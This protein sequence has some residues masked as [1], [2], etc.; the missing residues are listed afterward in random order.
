MKRLRSVLLIL[1]ILAPAFST[2]DDEISVADLLGN[3]NRQDD[4]IV[5][6]SHHTLWNYDWALSVLLR[7]MSDFQVRP[8]YVL[9]VQNSSSTF[10][11]D[12]AGI[13]CIST[14]TSPVGRSPPAV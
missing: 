7:S 12:A 4:R 10:I 5:G 6:V 13:T 1:L 8:I 11:P 3:S 9:S 14:V 2:R